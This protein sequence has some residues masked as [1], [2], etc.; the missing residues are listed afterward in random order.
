MDMAAERAGK[1][2]KVVVTDK[3]SAYIGGIKQAYGQHAEHIR[4]GPF[5]V[6]NDTNLIERFHN[7]LK[8]R[9]KV[10]RAQRNKKTL[11]RFTDGW[12]V[13]YNY[14]RPHMSLDNKTPAEAGGL[15]PPFT[16]WA[17]VVGYQK[18]PI[19]KVL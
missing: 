1:M 7:S 12:L 4:S 8:E 16:D 11:E 18:Q 3:L 14:F 2:P 15:K 17:D 6:E 10:M 13:H 9:T 19:V 5:V